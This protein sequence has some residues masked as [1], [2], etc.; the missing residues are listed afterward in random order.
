ML[1]LLALTAWW[2]LIICITL[3]LHVWRHWDDG[4]VSEEGDYAGES[5][6]GGT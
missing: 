5:T 2:T 3:L 6:D 4:V 1:T